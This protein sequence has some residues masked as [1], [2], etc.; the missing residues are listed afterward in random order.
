M[1]KHIA[2][3]TL[4][5]ALALA[6]CDSKPTPPAGS[7]D[8]NSPNFSAPAV[9]KA[10]LPPMPKSSKSFRCDDQSVVEVQLFQGDKQANVSADKGMPAVLKAEEASK[11]F[12]AEG[13]ELTVAGDAITLTR[14]GHPKQKCTS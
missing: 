6:A 13:Y 3:A 1:K 9:A 4:T 12:V 10:E 11:P 5:A 2:F 14:P 7:D 8:P